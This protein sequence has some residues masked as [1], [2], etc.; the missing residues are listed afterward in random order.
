MRQ[1]VQISIFFLI[2]SIFC[3]GQKNSVIVEKF[4][5]IRITD[6]NLLDEIRK[7]T[8]TILQYYMP[9]NAYNIR[10]LIS[11]GEDVDNKDIQNREGLLQGRIDKSDSI[12]ATYSI[13]GNISYSESK[14]GPNLYQINFQLRPIDSLV[15]IESEVSAYLNFVQIQNGEI[16]RDSINHLIKKLLKS[17]ETKSPLTQELQ[18]NVSIAPPYARFPDKKCIIRKL[19]RTD[20]IVGGSGI[21]LTAGGLIYCHLTSENWKTYLKNHNEF[22]IDNLHDKTCTKI[23]IAKAAIAVGVAAPTIYFLVKSLRKKPVKYTSRIS[24]SNNGVGLVINF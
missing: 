21:I 24:N 4:T 8:K 1:L 14:I 6:P 18:P 22:D 12:I 9:N 15:I 17:D 11:R 19:S 16:R 23:I 10:T 13:F 2:N 20:G 5:A 7:E 3:H